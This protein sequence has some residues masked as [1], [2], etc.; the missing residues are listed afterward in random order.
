MDWMIYN[1]GYKGESQEAVDRTEHWDT[2]RC[3]HHELIGRNS[4][5][6]IVIKAKG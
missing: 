2:A 6:T 3:Q 1:F 5:T 4:I